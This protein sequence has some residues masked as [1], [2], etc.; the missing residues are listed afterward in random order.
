MY[1]LLGA[2]KADFD[3]PLML[4]VEF[5]HPPLGFRG[6]VGADRLIS[7]AQWALKPW[8]RPVDNDCAVG[9]G[10]VFRRHKRKDGRLTI[11]AF[12]RTGWV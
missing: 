12:L 7:A 11:R 6:D 9:V 3:L 10:R 8:R 4:G 1:E 2:A 5:F